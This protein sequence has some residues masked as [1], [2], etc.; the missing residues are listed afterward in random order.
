MLDPAAY[1]W[2]VDS[3]RHLETH[4]SHLFFA[5]DRVVKLKRP[6]DYGFADL[7]TLESREQACRDEVRLN[8]RLTDDI[9]LEALPIVRHDGGL[10]LGGDGP[11]L[12]WATVMRRFPAES[13]LDHV[14]ANEA[15][16]SDL[17]A[18]LAERLIPFHASIAGCP[19]DPN[20]QADQAERIL[21]ENLEQIA[22]IDTYAILPQ[23]FAL[24]R[25]L[26]AEFLDRHPDRI[27]QRA[28]SGMI[29]EGHGDLKC[30]H[31][32]LDPPGSLQIFDCVEFSLEIRCADIASDLAFLLL[33]LKRLGATGVADELVDRYRAAGLD[34]PDEELIVYQLHRGLV[35]VK[36]TAL[37]IASSEQP[38]PE[39][40]HEIATWLHHTFQAGFEL[41]PVVLAMTG[42]SGSGKSAVARA[43]AA[44]TG[45]T[46]HSTDAI[47]SKNA[48]SSS[49]RYAP[50]ARLANYH[51]LVERAAVDLG[52][53]SPV[54]LDG[55]FLRTEERELA[56]EFAA[57]HY[58]PILF[59]EVT[60]N[61]D[62]MERRILARGRGESPS[63]AS[64]ATLDVLEAQLSAPRAP[65]P[66][67]ATV[68]RIE[69][70][71]DAPASLDPLIEALH[72]AGYL[73]SR[74]D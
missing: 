34:L 53:H 28:E 41:R 69:N 30:E 1:P 23:E 46:I 7:T 22:A 50:D 5:G 38:H 72:A 25:D 68:V 42:F 47:R 48:T 10:R 6:V 63:F 31:V 21:R 3:V 52:Q 11:P 12:D 37:T 24:I 29:R 16:P 2:R 43:I 58:A 57:A 35:K 36:T 19:G 73:R 45:A 40:A 33:D 13:S 4:I 65:F 18:C 20:E 26:I 27:R 54:I 51:A 66:A 17:A 14:L 55:A 74:L 59:I 67:A 56:A 44:L 15:A 70:S 8:R 39:L 62:V 64:E 32:L 61:R 49:A 60:A 71:S 9:Y